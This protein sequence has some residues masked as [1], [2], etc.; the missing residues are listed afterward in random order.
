MKLKGQWFDHPDCRIAV[1]DEEMVEEAGLEPAKRNAA[2]LQSAPFAARDTPPS[3]GR[4]NACAHDLM[5]GLLDRAWCTLISLGFGLST[6]IEPSERR[7]PP[8][9]AL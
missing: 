7:D 6:Q 3:W 8:E 1:G 2:D 9:L 5:P 4:T